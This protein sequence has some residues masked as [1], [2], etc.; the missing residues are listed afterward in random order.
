[1]VQAVLRWF[2][3]EKNIFKP[4]KMVKFFFDFFKD[5]TCKTFLNFLDEKIKKGSLLKF[6]K[7]YSVLRSLRFLKMKTMKT[8]KTIKHVRHTRQ[9]EQKKYWNSAFKMTHFMSTISKFAKRIYQSTLLFNM[10]SL[11]MP[12]FTT[13]LSIRVGWFMIEH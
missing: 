8:I 3:S 11:G 12:A 5:G 6:S 1:M 7:K 13:W 10:S 9:N 2:L 4:C